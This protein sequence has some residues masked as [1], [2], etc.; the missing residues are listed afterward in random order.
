MMSERGRIGKLFRER[1]HWIRAPKPFR[2]YFTGINTAK[3]VEF[4][5]DILAIVDPWID[6]SQHDANH[7]GICDGLVFVRAGGYIQNFAI[8]GRTNNHRDG[9][10]IRDFCF[11]T[12]YEKN[13]LDKNIIHIHS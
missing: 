3:Y 6:F 5:D 9:V 4:R 2:Y 8:S 1:L 11:E 7:D 13:P 10:T 12:E